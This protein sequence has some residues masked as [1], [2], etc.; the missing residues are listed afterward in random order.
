MSEDI[1]QSPRVPFRRGC[2][3]VAGMALLVGAFVTPVCYTTNS[4]IF[5]A[6]IRGKTEPPTP[7]YAGPIILSLLRDPNL[8]FAGCLAAT[9]NAFLILAATGFPGR[10]AG[11]TSGTSTLLNL[12]FCVVT[13]VPAFMSLALI[14][15]AMYLLLVFWL[16]YHSPGPALVLWG[17]T[18]CCVCFIQFTR[19]P[20]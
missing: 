10:P 14:A 9:L 2:I 1:D 6:E 18:V 3:A 8:A 15:F 20:D 12:V 7:L 4:T 17:M 11:S 5:P 19:P 16:G 13:T